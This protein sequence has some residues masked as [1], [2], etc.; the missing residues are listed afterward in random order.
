[1]VDG[2]KIAMRLCTDCIS[3]FKKLGKIGGRRLQIASM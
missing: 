2:K 3:R 1:M